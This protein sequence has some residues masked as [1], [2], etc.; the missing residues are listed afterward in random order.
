[1]GSAIDS[2]AD[3]ILKKALELFSTRGY[4]ATSVREIC[5]AAGITKPT[6]YHFFGSKEGVYR[7]LVDGTL[8]RYNADMDQILGEPGATRDRLKRLA[9]HSFDEVRSDP[10]V[11]RFILSL[12]Y[13]PSSA[14]PPT[15]FARYYEAQQRRVAACLEAGTA[16]G[17]LRPGPTAT[18]LL[19]FMGGI[20]ESMCGHLITGQPELT[21]E[22]ADDLV[23]T[24]LDGW[25]TTQAPA[26]P[27]SSAVS[28]GPGGGSPASR[29]RTNPSRALPLREQ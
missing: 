28:E 4:E 20:G 16:R 24:L 26:R 18:R 13:N 1:M 6:L 25:S 7:A 22:L 27:A 10:E 19:L 5:E 21:P 11:I 23:D 29:R 8:E 3:R 15:Q 9:R 2:T 17:E 14:A 12:L